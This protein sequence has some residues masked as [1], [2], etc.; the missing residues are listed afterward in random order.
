MVRRVPSSLA[1]MCPGASLRCKWGR[2]WEG[3]FL[4]LPEPGW[5]EPS[6]GGCFPSF[7]P[8]MD[9]GSLSCLIVDTQLSL[10]NHES[11]LCKPL[12]R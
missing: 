12:A 2:V 4:S 9:I 11:R 5:E 10:V 8:G 6:L 1:S 7:L 3:F